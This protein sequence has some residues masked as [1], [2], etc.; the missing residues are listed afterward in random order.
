M[1]CRSSP[2]RHKFYPIITVLLWIHWVRFSNNHLWSDCEHH[3]VNIASC[4]DISGRGFAHV[5]YLQVNRQWPQKV[6]CNSMRRP[7]MVHFSQVTMTQLSKS[8]TRP[9]LLF[10]MKRPGRGSLMYATCMACAPRFRCT[11]STVRLAACATSSNVGVLQAPVMISQQCLAI[12][13]HEQTSEAKMH[14]QS[15]Q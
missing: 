3:L 2:L 1:L 10:L 12:C 8:I 11:I 9:A 5:R 15:Q 14:A 7:V 6:L 4:C 13:S